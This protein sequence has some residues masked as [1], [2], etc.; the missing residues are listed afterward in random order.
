M[1]VNEKPLGFKNYGSIG[2]LPC[3]RMGPADHAVPQGM[4]DICTIKTRDKHDRVWVTEKLDGSNVGVALLNGEV[5]AVGRAG[6]L[7]QTSKYEQHKLFAAWVRR[8]Q[9]RFR[10]LLCEG[11][12]C[13]GEWLAQAHGTRY[14]LKHEPFVIFDLMRG[15]KRFLWE[16]ALERIIFTDCGF[17]TPHLLNDGRSPLSAK[18]AVSIAERDNAHGADG[19]EGAVWRVE[20]N[21]EFDFMA[22]Y[23]KPS[24]V[25]GAL[26]PEMSGHDAVWNWRP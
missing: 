6:W 10:R 8:E 24:K 18:D 25:D 14:S 20:R 16:N 19:I 11:E 7:A 2:H 13:C 3:S 5:L 21:G 22:K 1:N 9:E 15:Q 12:R 23:V 17:K 4:A 26:L